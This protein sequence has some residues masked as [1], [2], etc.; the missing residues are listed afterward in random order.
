MSLS[1]EAQPETL[2]AETPRQGLFAR[3]L[4][5]RVGAMLV[6]NTVV[7]S[8]VFVI[9][10][11]VLWALVTIVAMN[12][13]IAAGIGFIFANSLHYL[14][15]RSWIFRGTERGLRSGYLL[16]LINAGVGLIV[17]LGLFALL[18]EFTA[19]HYL[20]A[21]VVVSVVAGL[22]VFVLNAVLNFRQV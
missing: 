19:M 14:F 18:L 16:F 7:S 4:S 10:L 22:V 6:R 9:G 3:L 12:E 13:V 1:S 8:G 5:V 2:V 21:R 11:G 17:T 20:L 15:G